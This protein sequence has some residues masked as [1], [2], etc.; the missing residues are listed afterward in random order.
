MPSSSTVQPPAPPASSVAANC[1]DPP[2]APW[3]WRA[4]VLG[5]NGYTNDYPT[6]RL[7]RDAK[8]YEIGAG[9]PGG[10]LAGRHVHRAQSVHHTRV[11]GPQ[12]GPGLNA[13]AGPLVQGPSL[14]RCGRL[15]HRPQPPPPWLQPRPP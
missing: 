8:L 11:P 10:T 4:Q 15:E 6:G 7:L 5:G 12:V 14:P 1:F 2:A 13:Q 3:T 9:G